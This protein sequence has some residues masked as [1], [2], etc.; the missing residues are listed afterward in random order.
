MSEAL[1]PAMLAVQQELKALHDRIDLLQ[2]A[3]EFYAT[4]G[5]WKR[6]TIGRHWSNSIAAED[7]GSRARGVLLGLSE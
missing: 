1:T 3:V 7:R 4:D 2:R 5:N 6:S